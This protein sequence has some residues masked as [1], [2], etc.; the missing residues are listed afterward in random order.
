MARVLTADELQKMTYGH[1]WAEY[2][3]DEED[4]PAGP[5]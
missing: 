3:P 1:G 2:K 4:G 5:G